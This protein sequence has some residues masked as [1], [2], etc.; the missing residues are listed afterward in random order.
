MYAWHRCMVSVNTYQLGLKI[1]TQT[2]D[3]ALERHLAV[4]VQVHWENHSEGGKKNKCTLG[5]LKCHLAFKDF[6]IH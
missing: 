1:P 5:F 4:I 3:K 6:V 2:L